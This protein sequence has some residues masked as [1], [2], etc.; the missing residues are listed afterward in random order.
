M[1]SE[2]AILG[3]LRV[4]P[5]HGYEI[6]T[7][8][9]QSKMDEWANLLSGSIYYAINKLEKEKLIEPHKEERN[10][11]KIRVIYSITK[12]GEDH[13]EK[14]LH[15]KLEQQPHTVKSDFMLAL[16]MIDKANNEQII[17]VLE[18]NLERLYSYKQE[19]ESRKEKNTTAYNRL[20]EICFDSTIDLL[21]VDIKTLE[22]VIGHLK[23][24]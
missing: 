19:W 4:R 5:M 12:Q 3:L 15:E 17:S 11:S 16:S 23:T 22:D 20:M 10:G 7:I 1:M 8:I 9:Q 6:Q 13:Y 24:I 14:L 18:R 2:L 21:N